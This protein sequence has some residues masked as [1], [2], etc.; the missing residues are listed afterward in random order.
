[1]RKVERPSFELVVT[2]KKKPKPFWTQVSFSWTR[3]VGRPLPKLVVA[4]NEKLGTCKPQ[5][6][7]NLKERSW[8]SS[9]L[10]LEA[11]KLTLNIQEVFLQGKKQFNKLE[12]IR[13]KKKEHSLLCVCVGKPSSYKM[14][15][16]IIYTSQNPKMRQFFGRCIKHSPF[17]NF[18][19]N[20]HY[21]KSC[22][23]QLVL[24][25][26]KMSFRTNFC[27]LSYATKKCLLKLV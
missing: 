14:H 1:M 5:M 13:T 17:K 9:S 4:N 12:S 26:K 7:F 22:P 24:C 2:K 21:E 15:N 10:V 23:L 18:F 20:C 25:N 19:S 8:G 11:F 6:F 16:T 27:N 3:K